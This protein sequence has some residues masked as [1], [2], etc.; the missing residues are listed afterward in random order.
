MLFQRSVSEAIFKAVREANDNLEPWKAF[1]RKLDHNELFA[2]CMCIEYELYFN[3]VFAR[4]NAVK[5]RPLRWAN[6]PLSQFNRYR[7]DSYSYDYLSC[8]TYMRD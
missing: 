4:T 8:H 3:F 6:I 1:C 5:I 7:Q 2:S